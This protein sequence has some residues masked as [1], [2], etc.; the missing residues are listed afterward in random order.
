M[1]FLQALILG[2]VQ[3]LTEFLPVSSSGHLVLA[4]EL[5]GVENGGITFEVLVH[6]ATLLSVLIYFRGI[7][8]RLFLSILPPFKPELAGDRK[9]VGY[10]AAGTLPAVVAGLTF[11]DFF[12]G[13]YENPQAVSLFLLATGTILF[14]PRWMARR[15]NLAVKLPSALAMGIGQAFAILP[16]ISRSG[17]TIVAG[18]LAK[19]RPSDA[20]EFS[21][22]L[23]IP[24]IAGATVLEL[25]GM[26][27]EGVGREELINYATGGFVAFASGLLAIYTVLTAVRRGKFEWFAYY[28]YA[29]GIAAFCWFRFGA[30]VPAVS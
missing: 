8:R 25:K 14:L 12:E 15:G 30:A 21:F 9:K 1:N 18:M 5:M 24:A 22:L 3:G 23:A 19:T 4:Q 16:G 20:A 26:L 6:F 17:S 13:V 7:L 11:R 28:C 10:L 29:A 27:E 2:L